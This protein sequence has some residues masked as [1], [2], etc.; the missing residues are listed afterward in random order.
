MKKQIL[1]LSLFFCSQA[2]A[3]SCSAPIILSEPGAMHCYAR[4]AINQKGEAVVAWKT[5]SMPDGCFFQAAICNT[6]KKWSVAEKIEDLEKAI[7]FSCDLYMD[8]EGNAFAGWVYL[9][10]KNIVYK[11]SKKEKKGWCPA[12]TVLGSEDKMKPLSVEFDL[13][14]NLIILG[15]QSKETIN[16]IHYQQKSDI[17]NVKNML[18]SEMFPFQTVC[19]K[20]GQVVVLCLSKEIHNNWFSTTTD[21][22]V[23]QVNLKENGEWAVPVTLCELSRMDSS[24]MPAGRPFCS[25]NSN[26]NFAFISPRRDNNTQD[27]KIEAVVSTPGHETETSIL[28]TSKQTFENSKILIDDQGNALAAWIGLLKNRK[29]IF[30]AYKPQGQPW[31][32]PVPL[33]DSEKF[34]KKFELSRDQQGHFIIVW[35]EASLKN[36]FSIYGATYST[37]TQEWS[38]ALLSPPNQDCMDSS[39]AFNEKGEGIIAWTNWSSKKQFDIQVVELK[40]D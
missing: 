36:E 16:I 4:A 24:N 29:A 5:D 26:G 25:M 18:S 32:S 33:T 9:Q 8:N 34:V 28:A 7:G 19:H 30:A 23:Q 40:M 13:Q 6:E 38:L 10:D 22:K 17:K 12:K 37:Q 3:L 1:F 35:D 20:N 15:F 2:W 39:I 11:F 14:G 27:I 31:A 21:F